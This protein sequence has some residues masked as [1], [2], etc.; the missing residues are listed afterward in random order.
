MEIRLAQPQDLAGW[1][2]LVE[3]VRFSFPGLET[4]E[5]LEVHRQTVRAFMRRGWAVCA[6][7]RQRIAGVLLFSAEDNTL[8]FL[9]VDPAFRRRHAAADMVACGLAHMDPRRAVTVTTYQEGDP[10]GTAARA[11]Y[12]SLGFTEGKLTEEFGSPVQEFVLD[13]AQMRRQ[14]IQLQKQG[15]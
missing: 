5:A 15:E 13:A 6:V 9:A 11:F 4:P 1:M 3:K 14:T 7:E 8:C 12:K 10:A 2:E